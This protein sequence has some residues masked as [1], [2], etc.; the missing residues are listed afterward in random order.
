MIIIRFTRKTERE[1]IMARELLDSAV[2]NQQ[3]AIARD[4]VLRWPCSSNTLAGRMK[5]AK[6]Y[7]TPLAN[8]VR[9]KL[10]GEKKKNLH[11][12]YDISDRQS[13]VVV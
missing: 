4:S 2:Y 9:T 11:Y 12:I 3:I 13:P 6:K 7:T 1:L 8:D 5:M 10:L